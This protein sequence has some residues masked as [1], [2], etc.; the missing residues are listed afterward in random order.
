MGSAAPLPAPNTLVT[1]SAG[2]ICRRCDIPVGYLATGVARPP[3]DRA[4]DP[5]WLA[6]HCWVCG[7]AE[8]EVRAENARRDGRL[9]PSPDTA[10]AAGDE[11]VGDTVARLT[12]PPQPIAVTLTAKEAA[13][14]HVAAD[15]ALRAL[16]AS[17]KPARPAL[18]RGIQALHRGLVA[19]GC[20][21]TDDGWVG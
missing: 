13:E 19:A 11:T 7:E 6:T 17:D 15:L 18:E 8:A 5:D 14:L 9:L 10:I 2:L 3:D 4:D 21:L 1:V 12:Q 20:Q 16:A